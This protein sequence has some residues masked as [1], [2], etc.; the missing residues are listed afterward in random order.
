[1]I[2]LA[3]DAGER[4]CS[5]GSATAS[6]CE[7]LWSAVE[8]VGLV[9]IDQAYLGVRGIPFMHSQVLSRSLAVVLLGVIAVAA[10]AQQPP[11]G[12][13]KVVSGQAHVV[14]EGA[15]VP[16]EVGLALVETDAIRTGADGRV[17]V[18]MRDETRL[19][20]G[21][22][23]EARLDRFN[24][25]P[26]EGSFGFALYV[27]RGVATYVSGRIARL[28]PDAVR[29]ETPDAIVGVRGTEVAIHVQEQ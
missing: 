21:P 10:E 29:L 22:S 5:R 9:P 11:A 27:L 25:A 18:T 2:E 3:P 1:M 17:G 23:S 26:D 16:A 20:L 12:Q 14:R 8:I 19:S 15:L 28:A 7:H 6:H 13:I 4:P 24:Y